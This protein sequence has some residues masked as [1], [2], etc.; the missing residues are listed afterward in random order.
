MSKFKGVKTDNA[1]NTTKAELRNN[2][3]R[4]FGNNETNVL[5]VF[6]GSGEMFNQV[7][8][9]ASSYVGIDKK[10]YSDN[11]NTVCGDAV[12]VLK[13]FDIDGINIFDIDAYGDPYE[14]LVIIL[15]KLK[16]I[17][18]IDDLGFCITDGLQ[19]DMRMSRFR[20][21]MET[22]SCINLDKIRGVH[23]LHNNIIHRMVSSIAL[24]LNLNIHSAKIAIGKKGSGMR[25]YS[26]ILTKKQR[27]VENASDLRTKREGERI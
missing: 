3:L 17:K 5:D 16:K 24:D 25:Y 10:K 26:F 23:R 7:W 2:I 22:I 4:Y 6:C 19:I 1:K 9:N 20:K 14:C 8:I 15:D 11:R 13:Q 12:S 18:N 27:G 21:A